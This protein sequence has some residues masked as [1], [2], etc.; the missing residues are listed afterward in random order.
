[1]GGQHAPH[2]PVTPDDARGTVPGARLTRLRDASLHLFA[3]GW[4]GEDH[5]M[6]LHG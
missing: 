2:T 5:D 1:M 3:R 4:L 6:G